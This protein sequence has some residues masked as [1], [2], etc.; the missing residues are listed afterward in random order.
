MMIEC[1]RRA[2]E[3]GILGWRERDTHVGPVETGFCMTVPSGIVDTLF[4]NIEFCP[5]C[6]EEL[7]GPPGTRTLN[8]SV[9]SRT[10]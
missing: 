5:F 4:V 7:S 3:S 2:R 1:C 8:H 6:G 10:L 9:M